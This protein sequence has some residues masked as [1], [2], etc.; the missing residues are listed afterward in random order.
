M[1][2][3]KTLRTQRIEQ[4]SVVASETRTVTLENEDGDTIIA[5][6]RLDGSRCTITM[7][8]SDL[9]EEL[10]DEIVQS[11]ASAIDKVYSH[12]IIDALSPEL[13]ELKKKLNDRVAGLDLTVRLSNGLANKKVEFV[14]EL[15]QMTE[16][17]ILKTKY[18]GRKALGIIKHLL[19]V[20]G[21]SLGMKIPF[22]WQPPTTP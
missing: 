3:K 14:G 4:D 19:E 12:R 20:N 21:L 13:L 8:C 18:F 15:V 11:I 9:D 2:W 16:I 7:R 10:L 17:D 6:D 5:D 1:K 22:D